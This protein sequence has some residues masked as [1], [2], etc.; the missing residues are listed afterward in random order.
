[1]V[2][3][4]NRA[5]ALANLGMLLHDNIWAPRQRKVAPA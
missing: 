2:V 1:M 5:A 3:D 4:G